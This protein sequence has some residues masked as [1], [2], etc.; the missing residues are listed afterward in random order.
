MDAGNIIRKLRVQNGYTQQHVADLLRVSR[1]AYM[2]WENNQVE[3][4]LSRLRSLCEVYQISILDFFQ[5][6]EMQPPPTKLPAIAGAISF[7]DQLL[8]KL[9]VMKEQNSRIIKMNN[10]LIRVIRSAAK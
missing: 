1:N 9:A 3:L 10:K 2:A 4:T 6:N 5:A 7:R 8:D